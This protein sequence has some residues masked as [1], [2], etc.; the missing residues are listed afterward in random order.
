[1]CSVFVFM[2][3]LLFVGENFAKVVNNQKDWT[4]DDFSDSTQDWSGGPTDSWS[5]STQDWSDGPTDSW[6]DSTDSWS[7][8]PTD[9]GLS[10]QNPF[11]N[12]GCKLTVFAP[13]FSQYSKSDEIIKF[14]NFSRSVARQIHSVLPDA[15]FTVVSYAVKPNQDINDYYQYDEFLQRSQQILDA[16]LTTPIQVS[17]VFLAEVLNTFNEFFA[18]SY[19]DVLPSLQVV[20][21]GEDDKIR[22]PTAANA[23]AKAVS[24]YGVNFFVIDRSSHDF[25]GSAFDILTNNDNTRHLQGQLTADKLQQLQNAVFSAATQARCPFTK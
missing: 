1:M 15:W 4:T 11:A 5:D 3:L 8:G 2:A 14:F 16:Y 9:S 22:D 20:M 7:D 17:R 21:F 13:E 24:T 6:S 18:E 25:P 10:T 12:G 23:A 19:P